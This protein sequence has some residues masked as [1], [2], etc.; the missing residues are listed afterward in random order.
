[1]SYERLTDLDIRSAGQYADTL[2]QGS[3]RLPKAWVV[4]SAET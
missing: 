1:M 4:S 3:H 2:V